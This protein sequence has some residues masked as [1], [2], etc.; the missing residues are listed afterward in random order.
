MSITYNSPDVE[1]LTEQ[2]AFY[3]E[4]APSCV[5]AVRPFGE[6]ASEAAYDEACR[7]WAN[8][9]MPNVVPPTS[10]AESREAFFAKCDAMCRR[11]P[12]NAKEYWLVVFAC[13]AAILGLL[14]VGAELNEHPKKGYIMGQANKIAQVSTPI[15][16]YDRVVKRQNTRTMPAP[17]DLPTHLAALYI[18]NINA[19]IPGP[20]LLNKPFK[21]K[22]KHTHQSEMC[23]VHDCGTSV[24]MGEWFEVSRDSGNDNSVRIS[25]SEMAEL[26]EARTA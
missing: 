17:S 1:R 21:Y 20:H 22:D 16:K 4:L 13:H 15:S 18:G 23:V 7:E 3:Y 5:N 8:P 24:V 14:S 25:A 26:W 2:L 11:P 10:H 6:V 12:K 19:D 9:E